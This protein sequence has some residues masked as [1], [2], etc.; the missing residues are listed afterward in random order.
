MTMNDG[1]EDVRRAAEELAER[2]PDALAPLAR[3]AYNYRWSWLPGGPELFQAIDAERFALT[4]QNPVRLL[5]E[6]ST[7]RSAARRR[8]RRAC[9]SGP[10]RSRR[11]SRPTWTGRPTRRSI[12]ARPVAFLCAEYGIHVSMP[13]Y[14]G[15]LGALAGDLLKEASD[16]AVPIVAVGLMYRKGYFRQRI[17]AGGWQHEYWIDTDPQ[18]LPAALVT[19][20]GR[21]AADDRGPDLR[22]RRDRADLARRRRPRAAVP[23]RHRPPRATAPLERWITARLYESDEHIRVAQYVLLGAGGVRALTALGI[24]PGVI[25]LNEGHARSRRSSSRAQELALRRG[26]RRSG[27]PRRAS[28]PCSRPTRRCRPATTPTPPSRWRTRSAASSRP[29][30][31]R[32]VDEVIALGRTASR[33]RRRAVRRHAGGAADEPRRQRR[34]PPPRRGGARDVAAAVARA[35]G[36]RGADRPRDQRRPRPDLDRDADAR[37]ARPPPR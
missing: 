18:R 32:P 17:D 1:R 35:R 28:G 26:A 2:L 27:S 16:C 23:A 4:N 6:A 9:S 33:G 19:G 30:R 12:P 37:A 31:G 21:P 24:E 11:R 29:A 22:R 15:G 20:A 7:R 13:I 5:Q 34:Q 8:R 14:S 25:H 36:G 3:L 10:P